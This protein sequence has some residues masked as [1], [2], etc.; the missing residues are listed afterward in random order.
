MNCRSE[1]PQTLECWRKPKHKGLHEAAWVSYSG[2]MRLVRWTGKR[3]IPA[4]K[5][6]EIR[7]RSSPMDQMF[8][9]LAALPTSALVGNLED[10]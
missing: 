9:D 7:A 2:H 10:S 4:K 6:A 8:I 1:G 3:K 5:W